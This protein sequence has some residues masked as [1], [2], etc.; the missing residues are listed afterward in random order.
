MA[1]EDVVSPDP[2]STTRRAVLRTGARLAYAAPLVAAS[3]KLTAGGAAAVSG[4]V[5]GG[6]SV[7]RDTGANCRSQGG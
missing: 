5:F 7:C 6:E 1:N 2:I 4:P 3:M